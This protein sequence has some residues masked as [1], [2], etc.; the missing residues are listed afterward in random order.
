MS[1][2]NQWA[3]VSNVCYFIRGGYYGTAL[4]YCEDSL[5]NGRDEEINLLRG[6]IFVLL[7]KTAEGMRQLENLCIGSYS[8]GALLA[9]KFAHQ[10]AKN[11]DKESLKEIDEKI[12]KE[13]KKASSENNYGAGMVLYFLGIPAKAKP[14]ADKAI[15]SSSNMPKYICLLGWIE[16]S[17]GREL[18][19]SEQYFEQ[20]KKGGYLDAY[21]GVAMIYSDRHL[22][23][24]M[25]ITAQEAFRENGTFIPAVLELARALTIS[26]QWDQISSQL[27]NALIIQPEC[28]PAHLYLAIWA[29]CIKGNQS[30]IEACLGDLAQAVDAIE[31]GNHHLAYTLADIFIRCAVK[32]P[33]IAKFCKVLLEKALSLKRSPEYLA[34]AIRVLIQSEDIKG[35]MAIAKE[36]VM[37]ESDDPRAVMGIGLCYLASGKADDAANQYA[38]IKEAHHNMREN[39]LFM[40]LGALVAKY[41]DN[42]FDHFFANIKNVV[43]T[44]I[45][46][47]PS[48]ASGEKLIK[49]LDPAFMVDIVVQLLDYA[50]PV[51]SKSPDNILREA[52]RIL[53]AVHAHCPGITEVTFLLARV[54]WLG[55]DSDAAEKLV[56]NC[57]DR[58]ET[59]ADAYLLKAQIKVEKGRVEEAELCL[60]TGLSFNFAVRDSSLYHLIKAKVMKKKHEEEKA[61]DMLK[62]AL[63]LPNTASKTGNNFLAREKSEDMNKISIHLELVDS[64]QTL[65]KTDEAEQMMKEAQKQWE[66]QP[67]AEQLLLIH[68]QILVAKNDPDGAIHIL[69]KVQPH[70]S[71]YQAVRSKM[72]QIYLEE[73][74]DRRMFTICFKELLESDPSPATYALLGDAYMKVQ[75]PNKAIDVYEKALK[76]NP[77]DHALAQKIG[78]A[79]VQCHLY[80]KAVNYYEA[81]VKSGKDSQMRLKLANLLFEL[82]N[83]EKCERVLKE[84]IE[85]DPNPTDSA[86]M[87]AHVSYWNLLSKLHFEKG[88]WHEATEDLGRARSIQLRILSKGDGNTLQMRR[89]AARICCKLAE[90]YTN[91]RDLPKA[92]EL[93]KEAVQLNETDVKTILAL[94]QLYLMMG[95]LHLCNQQCQIALNIDKNNDEAT[96]MMADL[97]YMKNEGEQA[98]VHFSQL[99]DRY[100]TH[101]HA[102][103]RTIE[104][105]WRSGDVDMAEKQ[106]D[107][108]LEFNPRCTI[109]AGYNYCK[110]LH[111]WYCGE[112]NNALQAFNRARR[113]LEWGERA[114]YNMIEICLNPENEVIGGEVLEQS[115]ENREIGC[116]TAEKFLKELRYK[117]GLDQRYNL[118]ENYILMASRNK[119]SMQQAVNNLLEIVGPEG[120]TVRSVGAVLGVARGYMLMKQTPKAKQV[121]KRVLGHPWTLDDADFLEKCWLLLAD[122]YISQNKS[123]QAT[124]VL[125]TVLQR[126]A[127]SIRAFEFMGYLK[128][129]EQKWLDAAS[130]YEDAWRLC[131]HR[132]PIIGYKLA[133]NLMKC[134]KLFDCIEICHQVLE[135]FPTYPKIKREIMDKARMMIRT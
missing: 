40:F 16:R 97:L 31:P 55:G 24:E 89:E 49:A 6:C 3:T 122:L 58:N 80:S 134:K 91:R 101:Y 121:L 10:K 64:L 84:P 129:K 73:K 2:P 123:D 35:A 62:A 93:Y 90:L 95:K 107:A 19:E 112:P 81:A 85:R 88:N 70:Q 17:L 75:D 46:S 63:R 33:S 13:K 105:S 82:G 48:N 78:E 130:N 27:N 66:G 98:V 116:Q 119:A 52:E 51:P 133:Y 126:N 120:E 87:T 114:I 92:V 47:V 106:L 57:L 76:A 113:D 108:A 83:T 54:K 14:Y 5:R 26:G 29:V 115:E 42:S 25:A 104:L 67:E 30:D 61:V 125:R 103:A 74:K 118:M 96:L 86:T 79:Y 56:E 94:A 4:W 15:E 65:K 127:S 37:L 22:P 117:P 21:I 34:L 53:S 1:D 72:A 131:R 68:A 23:Q 50:P 12:A 32:I 41:K 77:K 128:E 8:L 124:A 11:P 100:P 135:H 102:L 110:G 71:N 39:P 45:A 43:D 109:D 20:A 44:H 9:L 111:E 38:F 59:L 28:V 60:D 132:N 36:L 99:L 18:K 7:D 69:S